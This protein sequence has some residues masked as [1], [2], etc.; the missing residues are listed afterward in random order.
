MPAD[1]TTPVPPANTSETSTHAEPS[2]T[3]VV[4]ETQIPLFSE[5][6]QKRMEEVEKE[7]EQDA[8]NTSTQKRNHTAGQKVGTASLKLRTKNY[9][10][11][12]CGAKIVASN[13]ESS[14]TR[15]VLTLTKDEYLLSPCTS[16]IWFV[17]EL[18]EAIQAEMIDL[19]NF[20]LFSS[21]PRN[22]SVAVANR[23]PTRDWSQVGR[24]TAH[25]ERYIQSFDLHPHLFGKYVRVDIHSHYNSEHFCP[26]SLF[27]VFGTS[28]F[29]AFETEN[30]IIGDGDDD[31]DDDDD[32]AA[33]LDR[34]EDRNIFKTASDAMMSIVK[35]AAT[36][37]KPQEN[38]TEGSDRSMM[39][40]GQ[41][42]R[43]GASIV[44]GGSSASESSCISPVH[45][46]QCVHCSDNFTAAVADVVACKQQ[47]LRRWLTVGWLYGAI[48]RS[49]ICAGLVGVNVSENGGG[50]VDC[51]C[52]AAAQ[53]TSDWIMRLLPVR[54]VAA[55]CNILASDE[56]SATAGAV[57]SSRRAQGTI[58]TASN[59]TI[60][61]KDNSIRGPDNREPSV[62]VVVDHRPAVIF[63]KPMVGVPGSEQSLNNVAPELEA[64]VPQPAHP[65]DDQSNGGH[66][67]TTDDATLL[68]QIPSPLIVD[69]D[70]PMTTTSSGINSADKKNE[71]YVFEGERDVEPAAVTP[72][73]AE[74]LR[75]DPTR[76]LAAA[77][78][79]DL[80]VNSILEMASELLNAAAEPVASIVP[81]TTTLPPTLL[82][83][84]EAVAEA[85]A[86]AVATNGAT[87]PGG[88]KVQSESVFL[89]LSNRV[90]VR[91]S[92]CCFE[93]F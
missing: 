73:V 58:V 64:A 31:D 39:L 89:R 7:Q 9:A 12:D 61:R 92:F 93:R 84:G 70:L 40:A 19:A 69:S 17:V 86:L 65:S 59:V 13:A 26:I 47:L 8:A 27:R 35:A 44:G 36:F 78:L 33:V 62:P 68:T 16:R 21:S 30:R 57:N 81:T 4:E 22:F 52:P 51:G 3:T 28:E 43:S 90:K 23:F 15:A 72:P 34:K 53:P 14:N 5:W 63:V 42:G 38:R 55:M 60:D 2:T 56:M 80:P 45:L 48:V 18:C 91:I 29:E 76:P 87:M 10:S 85:D 50:S 67:T 32:D 41:T 1:V 66:P 77:D 71:A 88:Q 24:F 82:A 11:P 25:D 6:A 46:V 49:Q 79:A 54:Y 74:P 37:V 83:D 75:P 20:E